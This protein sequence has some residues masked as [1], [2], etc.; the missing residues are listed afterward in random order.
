MKCS[1]LPH[2]NLPVWGRKKERISSSRNQI[3]VLK[4]GSRE[5]GVQVVPKLPPFLSLCSS[6][7][8]TRSNR[9]LI[10]RAAANLLLLLMFLIKVTAWYPTILSL[11]CC[12]LLSLP[13]V[14]MYR[15]GCTPKSNSIFLFSPFPYVPMQDCWRW[16]D[17]LQ[18]ILELS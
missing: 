6:V 4:L 10:F 16:V 18:L 13:G 1:W 3:R 12:E 8:T 17:V 14:R 2:L 7:S 9:L 15:W 5:E 11:F